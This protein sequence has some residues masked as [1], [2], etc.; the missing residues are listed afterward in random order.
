[1]AKLIRKLLGLG[2]TFGTIAAF[3]LS[4]MAQAPDGDPRSPAAPISGVESQTLVITGCGSLINSLVRTQNAA[5]STTSTGFV[6]LSATALTVPSG[7]TRCV[8]VLFTAE[9]ACRTSAASDFCYIRATDNG[10][11]M[12]PQGGGFQAM[13]SEDSTSS[14]HAYEWV[15]RVGAGSHTISIQVRVGSAAT[16]FFLDDW[17]FDVQTHF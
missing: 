11:E 8:K 6:T 7:Q 15:R 5:V 3:S 9:T 10:I 4:A 17:T 13:D 14:A 12:N 16:R 1:M 2:V